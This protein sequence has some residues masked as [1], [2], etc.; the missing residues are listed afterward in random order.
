MAVCGFGT[1]EVPVMEGVEGHMTEDLDARE[2][3][4]LHDLRAEGRVSVRKLSSQ[5]GVS[6]V[7]IRKDLDALS[8][9]ALLR[10]VRGGAVT[11]SY[12]LAQE[13]AQR[14]DLIVVTSALRAAHDPIHAARPTLAR[15]RFG[16][17]CGERL[18]CTNQFEINDMMRGLEA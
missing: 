7:T 16:A 4:I 1:F 3:V 9:R 11:T 5:L 18:S 13:I 17:G 10:R 8:E 14:Q 15:E 12:Y 2:E 6:E